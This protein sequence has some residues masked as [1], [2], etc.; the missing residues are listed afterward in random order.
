MTRRSFF[1]FA[2]VFMMILL[3]FSFALAADEMVYIDEKSQKVSVDSDALSI[4]WTTLP[5]GNFEA[6]T[7]SIRVLD[8]SKLDT[9]NGEYIIPV[10]VKLE[11]PNAIANIEAK[12]YL[13]KVRIVNGE[14]EG[15]DEP[16][17]ESSFVYN[18]YAPDDILNEG[19]VDFFA[20]RWKNSSD[21]ILMREVLQ[22]IVSTEDYIDPFDEVARPNSDRIR[23]IL[24][25]ELTEGNNPAVT[26]EFT[27][28]GDLTFTVHEISKEIIKA[29][30]TPGMDC[31]LG[32][33]EIT[34]L[35]GC[36]KLWNVTGNTT[37]E[38]FINGYTN[39]TYRENQTSFSNGRELW[40]IE[41]NDDGITVI[42]MAHSSCYYLCWQDD[43][44]NKHPE[45]LRITVEMAEDAK[46]VNVS[47]DELDPV[48][49]VSAERISHGGPD[50][51]KE[52]ATQAGAIF[53]YDVGT[54][55]ALFEMNKSPEAVISLVAAN[56]WNHIP[57]DVWV[58][59]PE[60][61]EAS[62]TY[63]I[64]GQTGDI[65]IKEQDGVKY[66]EI[67][68]GVYDSRDGIVTQD[69]NVILQWNKTDGGT[70]MEK[71]RF[72]STFPGRTWMDEYWAPAPET[73]LTTSLD[74]AAMIEMGFKVEITPGKVHCGFNK[75]TFP[76]IEQVYQLMNTRLIL[77]ENLPERTAKV[78][79]N[80]SSGSM[81]SDYNT[82]ISD[83][84]KEIINNSGFMEAQGLFMGNI[85]PLEKRSIGSMGIDY[86]CAV[87][88]NNL[89][90]LVQFYDEQEGIIRVDG[91]DG[92]Y[93][94]L[95]VEPF[96]YAV[97]ST[98]VDDIANAEKD[99]SGIVKK[100]TLVLPEHVNS[101]FT[102]TARLFPQQINSSDKNPNIKYY[103]RLETDVP[104]SMLEGGVD[105]YI[106][107]SMIHPDLTYEKA[108]D[109]K[110][111]KVVHLYDDDSHKENLFGEPTE[112]GMKFIVD[113][114]SPFVIEVEN[115]E[116][117][118]NNTPGNTGSSGGSGISITYNGGNS[119]STSN[120]AV[121][122]SV[123]IDGMPVSFTGDGRSFTVSG[124]PAGAKW[125]TVR[126]NSTSITTNFA[127][128]GNVVS[129]GIEIPKTG[130]I[131]LLMPVLA[132]IGAAAARCRRSS[133]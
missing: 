66:A 110:K 115:E 13:R 111:F 41:E 39:G 112:Y 102:F 21:E 105:V 72:K 45:I 123:E 57:L 5:E 126:W 10:T 97:S 46:V 87:T 109:D 100:P 103:L 59:V 95:E 42:P 47:A 127:P 86:Y 69:V 15:Y 20:I 122:T 129:A 33:A 113:S 68:R 37:Y 2:A 27:Q 74:M 4:N 121:P 131:S 88:E 70:M 26:Y 67:G 124:I 44:G 40:K 85:C 11:K 28:D 17:T 75:G 76:T 114:F 1:V 83:E 96:H 98:V 130:D 16:L 120:S 99:S 79:R 90:V 128:D 118:G 73:L 7:I 101:A 25:E 133:K 23:I 63:T 84:Q 35:S 32:D 19:F 119:F 30:Y 94:T 6:P 77:G 43:D 82:R 93:F 34:T 56:G 50:S 106:P 89:V 91:K 49:N 78:K 54:G 81:G 36:N 125:I 107:Y 14:E 116:Q 48:I 53:S 31:I 60:G 8:R 71:F 22:Y 18:I 38:A 51:M 80:A 24:D 3:A 108:L 64:G 29:L 61:C 52:I 9:E 65:N 55:I 12:P 92:Y 132:L 62:G 104:A 117:S 58:R